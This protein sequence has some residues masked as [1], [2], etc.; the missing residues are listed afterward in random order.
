MMR[1]FVTSKNRV[2]ALSLAFIVAKAVILL[3][4]SFYTPEYDTVSP[5]VD[6]YFL[7]KN[8]AGSPFHRSLVRS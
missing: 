8:L 1:L 7:S 3:A 5:K 4:H 6:P 2:L